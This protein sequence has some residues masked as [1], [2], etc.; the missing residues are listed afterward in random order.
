VLDVLD[1]LGRDVLD[2]LAVLVVVVVIGGATSATRSSEKASTLASIVAASPDVGHD[3]LASALVNPLVNFDCAFD[4]P[5]AS[6]LEF[7]FLMLMPKAF[8]RSKAFF[9]V[10]LAFFCRH[11]AMGSTPACT[12]LVITN[13]P[14]AMATTRLLNFIAVSLS[15]CVTLCSRKGTSTSTLERVQIASLPW[16]MPAWQMFTAVRQANQVRIGR[17]P[18]LFRGRGTSLRGLAGADCGG[19]PFETEYWPGG[20]R[21]RTAR[22]TGMRVPCRQQK[23]SHR[24][25][26]TPGV[27]GMVCSCAKPRPA[28][29]CTT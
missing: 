7:G 2:V 29:R 19:E 17:M 26:W 22:G 20:V 11:A 5:T 6:L 23:A 13:T 9:P 25:A 27:H 12:A 4:M 3:P 18:P 10:T 1:V 8:R 28:N 16:T 21:I 14:T 15:P 24:H